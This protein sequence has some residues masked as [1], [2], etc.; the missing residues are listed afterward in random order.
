MQFDLNIQKV[1]KEIQKLGDLDYV[2]SEI[3]RLADEVRQFDVHMK[4]S[5]SARKRLKDLENRYET[6]VRSLSKAQKQLDREFSKALRNIKKTHIEVQKRFDTAR[7]TASQQKSKISKASQDLE[8]AAGSG[9][10]ARAKKVS[11]KKTSGT[12]KKR[13]PSKKNRKPNL[14]KQ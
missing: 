11:V 1:K 6:W 12:K 9:K 2:R 7:R 10:K 5:P 8:G 13:S 14:S 4:L 3:R